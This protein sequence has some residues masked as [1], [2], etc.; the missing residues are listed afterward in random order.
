[1]KKYVRVVTEPTIDNK[2]EAPYFLGLVIDTETQSIVGKQ[3]IF[4]YQCFPKERSRWSYPLVIDQ[5]GTVDWGMGNEAGGQQYAKTDLRGK[6]IAPG[7][8]FRVTGPNYDHTFRI[9]E[10]VYPAG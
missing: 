7:T 6:P 5:E 2:D 10:L 1:M 3:L 8:D 4:A 9:K